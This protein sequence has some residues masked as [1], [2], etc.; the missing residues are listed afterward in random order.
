MKAF[1]L[2][3]KHFSTYWYCK[4]NYFFQNLKTKPGFFIEIIFCQIIFGRCDIFNTDAIQYLDFCLVVVYRPLINANKNNYKIFVNI[5]K[6]ENGNSEKT[7]QK[8]L[9]LQDRHCL[10]AT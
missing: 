2:R 9:K 5:V 10:G 6:L 4:C 7:R 8:E 1:M 3:V